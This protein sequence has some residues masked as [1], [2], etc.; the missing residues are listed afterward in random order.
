MSWKV[1]TGEHI[2]EDKVYVTVSLSNVQ[3]VNISRNILKRSQR[4]SNGSD[5]LKMLSAFSPNI[6]HNRPTST[7]ELST[8][9]EH[10]ISHDILTGP[11]TQTQLQEAH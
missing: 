1:F 9:D 11:T 2:Y 5:S 6:P 8:L 7:E 3:R 4:Q 10:D